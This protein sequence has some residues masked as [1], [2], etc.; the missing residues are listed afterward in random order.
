MTSILPALLG[1]LQVQIRFV[2]C[3]EE[4]HCGAAVIRD[5]KGHS[6][7]VL[8]VTPIVI[9]IIIVV[10]IVIIAII[11]IVI[12]V[13]VIIIIIVIVGRSTCIVQ[14][15]IFDGAFWIGESHFVVSVGPYRVIVSVVL[16]PLESDLECVG[17][18]LQVVGM[19]S[20]PPILNVDVGAIKC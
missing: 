20:N 19:G 7:F 9:V 2:C 12:I 17:A 14:L 3:L 10:V 11:V 8:H 4:G 15:M 13:V 5:L 18:W 1:G 6:F 16:T